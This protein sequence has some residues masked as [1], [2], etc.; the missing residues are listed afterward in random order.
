LILRKKAILSYLIL[1]SSTSPKIRYHFPTLDA[2]FHMKKHYAFIFTLF[3]AANSLFAGGFQLNT[4]GARQ[5]GMG[6]TGTGLATDASCLFF[7]PAAACFLQHGVQL[8]TGVSLL[9][10]R[11]IYMQ[12]PNSSYREYMN[13]RTA[14][15]IHFYTSFRKD[16]SSR[17][18]FGLGVYNP[19]GSRAEWPSQWKGQFIIRSIELKT[20]YI[21]PTIACRIT[22]W[23]SAGAG[24]VYA[25]GNFG[26]EKGVPVQDTTGAYGTALLEGGASGFGWNAG[27]YAKFGE[28]FSLGISMRSSVQVNI[29]NGNADFTVPVSLSDLFPDGNFTTSLKL[30]STITLGLGY[31]TDKWKF[32]VDINRTAWSSYDSLRI[33]FE[34][35]TDKIEDVA[36]A[37]LYKDVFTFRTGAEYTL[38]DHFAFRAGFYYDNTPVQ[39][40]YLSPE[41]PDSDRFGITAGATFS[42]TRNLGLSLF[43]L[44]S[45]GKER[46]DTNLETQFTGT[47]KTIVNA[48]GASFTCAF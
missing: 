21:Q 24:F 1:P 13:A 2:L 12:S 32:A 46:T 6:H 41:A 7:N 39:D 22:D 10:P 34:T 20:F 4:Q 47:Y 45:E 31:S 33:D 11:T 38:N 18:A 30:P 42:L 28:H 40:G 29:K 44:Y 23:L 37:R 17:F 9:F 26:L 8:A 43:Y 35:N 25:T 36:S 5:F 19:Y 3:I 15:P 27:V 16:S 14:T 48:C